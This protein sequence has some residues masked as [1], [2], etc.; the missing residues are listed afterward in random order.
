MRD[1]GTT[2]AYDGR[3][4]PIVEA[5]QVRHATRPAD[6]RVSRSGSIQP[7]AGSSVP[8]VALLERVRAKEAA[9]K[10]AAQALR[11]K[12]PLDDG[13]PAVPVA[14]RPK[15]EPILA[16]GEAVDGGSNA[17]AVRR[18]ICGKRPPLATEG[19]S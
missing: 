1:D 2:L 15:L 10:A 12:R 6:H 19:Q 18:R 16:G 3:R 4:L 5:Q 8:A 17:A 14:Q 9:A 7:A 13:A 11:D